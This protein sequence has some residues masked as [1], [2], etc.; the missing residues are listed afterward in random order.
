MPPMRI[1]KSVCAVEQGILVRAAA[2]CC[3]DMTHPSSG[4]SGTTSRRAG[5]PFAWILAVAFLLVD[6]G[7]IQLDRMYLQGRLGERFS[8][9]NESGYPE[10]YENTKELTAVLLAVAYLFRRRDRLYVCWTGIFT[11]IFVDDT[12]QVHEQAGTLIEERWHLVA[13]FGLRGQ[14]LGELI[15]SSVAGALVCISLFTA[16][17][18]SGAEARRLSLTLIG[19]LMGLAFFGVFLDM[20]HIIVTADPWNYRLGIIEDGGEML[21]VTALLWALAAHLP[22]RE[23]PRMRQ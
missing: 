7:F 17:R 21:M 2:L 1:S 8:F 15:V 12:F 22:V 11:Y 23:A 14:D 4:R 18:R 3:A 19:L 9:D 6:V 20:L 10:Y 5:R 13:P 16:W